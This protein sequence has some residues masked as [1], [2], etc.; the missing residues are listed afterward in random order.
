VCPNCCTPRQTITISIEMEG[1]WTVELVYLFCGRAVVPVYMFYRGEEALAPARNWTPVCPACSTVTML[2][3]LK[4]K[5]FQRQ[6][7]KSLWVLSCD[8]GVTYTTIA[9]VCYTFLGRVMQSQVC[10]QR[11]YTR[12]KHR[13]LIWHNI[14]VFINTALK[15]W[16]LTILLRVTLHCLTMKMT[17]LR[18]FEMLRTVTPTAQCH[19]AE[20][21]HTCQGGCCWYEDTR[22]AGW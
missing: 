4:G 7:S 11:Y 18:S 8:I 3:V 14:K 13:Q 1:G 16:N 17:E 10:V 15:I 2:I 12:L 21:D 9:K 22:V 20:D 6:G 19:T 5:G